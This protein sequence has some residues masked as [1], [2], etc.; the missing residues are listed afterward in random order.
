SGQAALS[1]S[2]LNSGSHAI[3][4]TYAGDGNFNGSSGNVS[5]TVNPLA[6]TTTLTSNNNPSIYQQP[7]TFTATV[8]SSSGTPTGT[9]TFFDGATNIGSAPLS[10]GAASLPTSALTA[11]ASPHS[12]TAQYGGATN[13][14]T[15]TSNTVSQVVNKADQT[16]SFSTSAPAFGS[17]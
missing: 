17:A 9:V 1:T 6:T 3:S 8:T 5:Q 10:G 11:A 4:A 14:A 2:A 12:M 15:S 16:I 7:V 13:Y